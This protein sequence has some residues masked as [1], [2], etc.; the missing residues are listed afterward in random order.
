MDR[1]AKPAVGASA[2]SVSFAILLIAGLVFAC[3]G[4]DRKDDG[5]GDGGPDSDS[6]SHTPSDETLCSPGEVW[7]DEGWIAE[8]SADGLSWIHLTF[9]PDQGLVCAAG[10]CVDISAQ[11]AEAINERSYVGCEYWA[12]TLANGVDHERFSFAV[13][14]AN[15]S[16]DVANVEITDGI[17]VGASY[18]VPPNDMIVVQDLDW[19][20]ALKEPWSG[21][22]G[23]EQWATRHLDHGAYRIV[24]DRPISA[25]QFSPLRYESGNAY[26]YTNDASL[27]LPVHVYRDEYLVISRQPTQMT[28]CSG[29]PHSGN[30]GLFAVVGVEGGETTVEITTDAYTMASDTYSMCGEL[31][32]CCCDPPGEYDLTGTRIEVLSGPSPAVFGGTLCSFVPYNKFAC[33]HLEH[34]LFPLETWGR[35]HICAHNITQD[36]A[37]PTVW[38]IVSG[39]DGNSITFTPSSVHNPVTLDKGEYIEFESLGDFEV[40]GEDRLA[41]AQFLVGQNYT[42]DESPPTEGDPAMALVVP[43]EQLRNEYTFLTPPSYLRNYL[44]VI[45]RQGSLPGFDGEQINGDTVEITDEWA[46]TNFEI[47]EGIHRIDSVEPF[48]IMVYGV[49]AYTSYLY[50]GGLDL[51]TLEVPVE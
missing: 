31:G 51:R 17:I 50:A 5:E 29:T 3:S 23:E 48:G 15:D 11:C 13:A 6:D 33:D 10:E 34:Q 39:S 28:D 16:D 49:G 4:A 12:V 47:D 38:R 37:E 36:P 8:C 27:L 2:Q 19:M 43:V 7:C 35:H 25:Y 45:H 41:V 20:L 22:E 30:P 40:E 18:A 26:S 32:L 46:R 24:S 14:L 42:G 44:T 9:C 21:E 1:R